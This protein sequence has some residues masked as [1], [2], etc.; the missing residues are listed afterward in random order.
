[1]IAAE[2]NPEMEGEAVVAYLKVVVPVSF[3]KSGGGGDI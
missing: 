1:L 3:G 2:V